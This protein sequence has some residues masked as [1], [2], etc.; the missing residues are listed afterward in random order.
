MGDGGWRCVIVDIAVVDVGGF[1]LAGV[2]GSERGYD[3]FQHH[4]CDDVETVDGSFSK[5]NSC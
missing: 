1:V 4:L 2:A 3:G 5:K